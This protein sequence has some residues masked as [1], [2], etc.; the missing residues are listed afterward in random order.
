MN[1][2]SQK[3]KIQEIYN[4]ITRLT[5]ELSKIQCTHNECEECPFRELTT[6][7]SNKT[8]D[9]GGFIDLFMYN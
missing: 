1:K 5:E 2:D 3:E 9:C 8:L 7:D 6:T 4:E